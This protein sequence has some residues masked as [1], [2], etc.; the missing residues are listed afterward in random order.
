MS[1]IVKMSKVRPFSLSRRFHLI[2]F[3][4]VRVRERMENGMDYKKCYLVDGQP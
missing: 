4:M 1:F 2:I 3:Q